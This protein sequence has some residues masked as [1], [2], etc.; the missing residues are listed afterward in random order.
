MKNKGIYCLENLWT[1]SVKDKLSVQPIL[2][3]LDKADVCEHVY[4]NCATR[5]EVDFMLERWKV[6]SI[7]DKFPILYFAFHGV[8]NGICLNTKNN[9]YTLDDLADKLEDSCVGKVLF[10]A[11]CDTLDIDERKIHTFLNKTGA[12]A[13]IGYK[14]SVDWM[15]A[16]AFELLVFNA[17][18]EDL[19][20][21][22]GINK[23]KEII[24]NDYGNLYKMNK[25][26]MVISKSNFPRKRK[27]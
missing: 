18:Q 10:F 25:F 9:I 2:D 22:K 12:I 26:R 23:V 4:H 8:K 19:F 1:K 3:L 24:E 21:T 16:T 17:L 5:E 14:I 13:A 7:Q 20:D 27:S 11:S 15:L 6:K